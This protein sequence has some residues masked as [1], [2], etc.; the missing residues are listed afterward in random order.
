MQGHGAA[1]QISEQDTFYCRHFLLWTRVCS[2]QSLGHFH[3]DNP[4][5]YRQIINPL[6]PRAEVSAIAL[7]VWR[8]LLMQSDWFTFTLQAATSPWGM[9]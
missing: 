6:L 5:E 2:C 4:L 7:C 3:C 9:H 1:H 8:L